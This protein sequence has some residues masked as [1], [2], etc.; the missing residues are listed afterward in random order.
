VKRQRLTTT[1]TTD[2]QTHVRLVVPEPVG[3]G[4][5]GDTDRVAES[6]LCQLRDV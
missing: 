2:V 6:V 1:T 5:T 3:D 4:Q